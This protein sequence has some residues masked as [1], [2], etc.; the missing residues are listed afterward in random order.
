[1]KKRKLLNLH[2][3]IIFLTDKKTVAALKATDTM[4]FF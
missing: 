3:G 4:V 2:Y 1:M